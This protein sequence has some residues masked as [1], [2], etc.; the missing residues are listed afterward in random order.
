MTRSRSPRPRSASH[1]AASILLPPR[2]IPILSTELPGGYHA[3]AAPV[4][5][6]IEAPVG[7]AN[8]GF[9]R[10]LLFRA[11]DRSAS[12][13]DRDGDALTDEEDRLGGDAHA[14]PFAH[15]GRG[16]EICSTQEHG[17]L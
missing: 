2:S 14:H 5:G 13:A 9:R 3:I 12:H 1:A 6:Q 16:A 7:R 15:S 8:Q 17:E 10:W 4:L 11:L